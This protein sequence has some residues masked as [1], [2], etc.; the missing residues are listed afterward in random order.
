MARSIEVWDGEDLVGG[1]YGVLVGGVFMGE[2][3]FHRR[4]DAS[5]VALA[6]MASRLDEAGAVLLDTQFV[7]PHLRRMGAVEVSRA[8]FLSVLA[9]VRDADVQLGPDRRVVSR[10]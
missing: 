10:L 7:T 1:M 4:S 8:R 5:K 9:D 2:S 3:M 6:D